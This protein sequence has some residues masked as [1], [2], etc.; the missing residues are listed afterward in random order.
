MRRT[1]DKLNRSYGSRILEMRTIMSRGRSHMRS[2]RRGLLD[3]VARCRVTRVPDMSPLVSPFIAVC[4]SVD[5]I[6][7]WC[8]RYPTFVLL[9]AGVVVEGKRKGG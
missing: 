6:C 9:V 2:F 4:L 3:I 8:L 7:S 1:D 5:I